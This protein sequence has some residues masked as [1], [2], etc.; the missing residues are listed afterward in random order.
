MMTGVPASSEVIVRHAYV[1]PHH[2]GP[3][4]ARHADRLVT[5]PGL[6][7][8][9]EARLPVEQRGKADADHLVVVG[10]ED[11]HGRRAVASVIGHEW[12]RVVATGIVSDTVVPRPGALSTTSLAPSSSARLRM[13]ASP[14]AR[15]R[16]PRTTRASG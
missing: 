2:V 4:P 9:G 15:P 10:D 1:H 16:R 13:L 3:L 6:A 8:H 7:H 5:G 12:R 11:A 14:C